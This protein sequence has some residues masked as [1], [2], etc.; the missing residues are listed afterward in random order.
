MIKLL[1]KS[2]KAEHVATIKRVAEAPEQVWTGRR[3]STKGH[4][5]T[6]AQGSREYE[7]RY[8]MRFYY[9]RI[10]E[11][12][13][14]I[15]RP[16]IDS[17][18]YYDDEYRSPLAVDGEDAKKAAWIAYNI[19]HHQFRADFEKHRKHEGRW[20]FDSTYHIRPFVCENYDGC[21]Y[22]VWGADQYDTYRWPE[23]TRRYL[24]DQELDELMD[25]YDQIEAD[26]RKR[27]DAY[28]NRYRS[29]ITSVG[30]WANR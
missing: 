7:C 4:Y 2:E 13:V 8:Y 19:W 27:L 26:Y 24:T 11:Q 21:C 3:Y 28:W 25:C 15:D 18:V 12:V 23:D 5:S 1:T 14:K 6:T 16:S 30:Y 9:A 22:V 29:K 17:T 10:G 20:C